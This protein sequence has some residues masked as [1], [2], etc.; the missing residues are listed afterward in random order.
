MQVL[1]SMLHYVKLTRFFWGEAIFVTI[2]FENRQP[3]KSVDNLF[4]YE[5]WIGHKL[6]QP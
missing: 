5:L 4:P 2:Y 3:S 1:L 6:L